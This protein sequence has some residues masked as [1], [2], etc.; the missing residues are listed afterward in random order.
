MDPSIPFFGQVPALDNT[1]GAILLGSNISLIL[2]GFNIHQAYRYLRQFPNDSRFVKFIVWITLALETMNSAFAMHITYNHLVT[3]YFNPI[4]LTFASWAL[5]SMPIAAGLSIITSQC[6]FVRRVYKIGGKLKRV[7]WLAVFLL[8]VEFAFCIAATVEAFV[9][10][11]FQAYAKVTWV[12]S[13]GFGAFILT[14]GI[15]TVSLILALHR[16]RTG[17]KSTDS[18]IDLIVLY[19]VTTGLLTTIANLVALFFNALT[20]PDNFIYV[21]VNIVAAKIC[22]T[23]LFTALNARIGLSKHAASATIYGTG[24]IVTR[25]M[26]DIRTMEPEM[27]WRVAPPTTSTMDSSALDLS[28]SRITDKTPTLEE[29]K[30][31]VDVD[32]NIYDIEMRPVTSVA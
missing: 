30:S 6:F 27:T 31:R 8:V 12:I 25:N 28:T 20:P 2:Y 1:Y 26:N 24:R 7:A 16:S 4:E 19:A 21:G 29:S 22:V 14:D 3:N 32:G 13:A 17:I 18:L 15:L 9:Q 23:S 10:P 11:S 5:D